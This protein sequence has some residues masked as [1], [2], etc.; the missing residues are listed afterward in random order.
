MIFPSSEVEGMLYLQ[1]KAR[2]VLR[3]G[4]KVLVRHVADV[5]GD[6]PERPMDLPVECPAN[7]G[8]WRLPALAVVKALRETGEEITV[9]GPAECFV[10]IVPEKK[11]NRTHA[12]RTAA[13]FLL[14]MLG[15]AFAITWFHAD[16][17]MAQAQE[18]LF[19]MVTGRAPANRLLVT[20]PY[21]VGVFFGVALFYCLLG[22]K[23]TVSPLDIKLGEYRAS[24]ERQI[25][26]IP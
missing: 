25:G 14:L 26:R 2:A 12:L 3:P 10:H 1:L 22:R 18:T 24:A 21:A 8:V 6:G 19:R 20:L 9:I 11:R 5:M 4:E 15:S 13:A 16:V 7:P 23:G 17:N